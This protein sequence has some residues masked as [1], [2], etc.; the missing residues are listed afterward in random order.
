M[1][2][3]TACAGTAA[4][5]LRDNID[6]DVIVRIERVAQGKRG[7]FGPWAFEILRY[8]PDGSENPEF[9][10][11]QAPFR[12]AKVLLAG[13]NFG[14]GSSREMA[15]WA[16]DDFGI[17]CV[18]AES[19]G[20]IFFGNCRQIG[21]LPIVMK[22]DLIERLAAVAVRGVRIKVDLRTRTIEADGIAP[23]AFDVA[24]SIRDAFLAGLDEIGV[25]LQ[26]ADEIERF[27]RNDRRSRPWIY[28]QTA[29]L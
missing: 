17:R 9:I 19:F 13:A 16:L 7:E 8:L 18:I 21:V 2:A 12:D 29:V 26:R 4:P 14:C 1:K 23:I 20:D 22:R 15:V 24:P 11:N 5:L 3:F 10:L 27:E 25:T 6:T 28:R